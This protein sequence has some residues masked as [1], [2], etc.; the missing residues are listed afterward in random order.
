MT[1]WHV[2]SVPVV[3]GWILVLRVLLCFII[4]FPDELVILQGKHVQNI[5]KHNRVN[6]DKYWSGGLC[7]AIVSPTGW[8]GDCEYLYNTW[9]EIGGCLINRIPYFAVLSLTVEPWDCAYM[10]ATCL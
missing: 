2:C 6:K 8:F 10:Y 5:G 7:S 3:G 1:T 9:S 4:I